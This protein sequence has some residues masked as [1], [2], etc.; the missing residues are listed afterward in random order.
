MANTILTP[1]VLAKDSLRLL[2]NTVVMAGKVN[3]Q[4]DKSFGTAGASV[5]GKIGPALR[6]RQSCQMTVSE[7]SN[8]QV[9]DILEEYK[10]ITVSNRDQV[11]FK[12]PMQDLTL[13]V[14][15]YRNRYLKPAMAAMAAK[16]DRRVF[17][18]YKDIYQTVGTAGT[19]T[20]SGMTAA[21]TAQVYLDAGAMLSEQ[22]AP[23]SPRY[24]V[25]SPAVQAATVGALSG[26]FNAS[27][28]ISDQYATGVMGSAVLGYD[29]YV[30]S[31]TPT[32]TNSTGTAQANVKVKGASQS[33]ATLLCDATTGTIFKIGDTFSIGS[34]YSVNP[35]SFESTQRAAQFVVT[36]DA[37]ASSSEVTLS[38]SPSIYAANTSTVRQTVTA[39]PA[40][41]AAIT[42]SDTTASKT[43]GQ[44]LLFNPE[45]F[46][47][48]TTN[49]EMPGTD[50]EAQE[51]YEGISMRMLKQYDINSDTQPCRIDILSGVLTLQPRFA[52]RLWS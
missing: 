28:K 37:T 44:G 27:S 24:A 51:Q 31:Q 20:G 8:L 21:A 45:A 43:R 23:E 48:V 49:L 5:S 6:V 33:G 47:L 41:D 2:H 38:I 35:E 39:L 50:W 18:L 12:F 7:G 40:D 4:Y 13:S 25:I 3:R 34:I 10:T 36:A 29:W 32:H 9:Q 17:G 22:T 14:D 19:A 16:I 46:T 15:M 26:L 42:F 11:S 1:T 30:S 52:V